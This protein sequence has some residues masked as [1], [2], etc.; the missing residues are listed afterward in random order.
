[1][2]GIAPNDLRLYVIRPVCTVMGLGGDAVEELL[3]GTAMQESSCGAR[4]VQNGGPALGVWQMEPATHDD[5]WT[6]FLAFRIPLADKVST[7]L[8]TALPKSVQLIGN[9]YYACAM[10]RVQYFRSPRPIP[11]A[12]DI[13]GQAEL[14]KVAYN[15]PGKATTDEYMANAKRVFNV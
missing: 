6:N 2:S 12:G 8:F 9:L 15:G 7:F 14:Y 13:E 11:S 10:A 4:I 3:L 1:M 5:L